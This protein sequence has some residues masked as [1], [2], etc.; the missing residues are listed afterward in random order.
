MGSFR[1]NGQFFE[2]FG[3]LSHRHAY[4]SAF[5][6]RY[7]SACH[8][9]SAHY[10]TKGDLIQLEFYLQSG[11]LSSS[12]TSGPKNSTTINY[13]ILE[14]FISGQRLLKPYSKHLC[15]SRQCF[16]VKIGAGRPTK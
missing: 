14:N 13:T 16:F 3:L 9:I 1:P 15:S 10:D 6:Y 8:P 4:M 2:E 5:N 7:S 11:V 12:V